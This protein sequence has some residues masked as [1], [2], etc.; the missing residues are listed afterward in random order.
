LLLRIVR[1]PWICSNGAPMADK[2][3]KWEDN[4]PGRFYVDKD[5]AFCTTCF[6]LAPDHFKPGPREDHHFLSK[7]PV[8]ADELKRVLFALEQ[9]PMGAIGDDG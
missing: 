3:R 1:L 2:T 4:V 7:Q 6:E 5:C 9:C 8:T